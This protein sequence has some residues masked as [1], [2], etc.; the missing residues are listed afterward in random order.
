LRGRLAAINRKQS[1]VQLQLAFRHLQATQAYYCTA[2][3]LPFA[4]E[5]THV[6]QTLLAQKLRIGAQDLQIAA[7]VL[8]HNAVL[9][10]GQSTSFCPSARSSD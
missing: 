1:D 4:E 7:I 10:T 9:V 5:A 8:A 2:R 6:H 3:I